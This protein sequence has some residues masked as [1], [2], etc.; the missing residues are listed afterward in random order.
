[1]TGQETIEL[2]LLV[3]SFAESLIGVD[4]DFLR[5]EV[6]RLYPLLPDA[7]RAR[8]ARDSSELVLK[9]DRILGPLPPV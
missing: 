6:V 7:V 1:M 4:R 2:D 3:S 5:Q 8:V 9:I